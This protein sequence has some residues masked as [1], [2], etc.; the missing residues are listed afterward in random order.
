MQHFHITFFGNGKKEGGGGG[1]EYGRLAQYVS[2]TF[3]LQDF[4]CYSLFSLFLFK[5]VQQHPKYKHTT[6]KEK[7]PDKQIAH[8]KT[9]QLFNIVQAQWRLQ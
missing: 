7:H 5:N 9:T 1:G 6:K 4:L 8:D 2:W 3:H